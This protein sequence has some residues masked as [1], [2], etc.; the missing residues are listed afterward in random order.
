MSIDNDLKVAIM[1]RL[2]EA[3]GVNGMIYGQ[4]QDLAF[5]KSKCFFTTITRYPSS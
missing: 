5:E 4:Q 2:Y 3:S 1:T